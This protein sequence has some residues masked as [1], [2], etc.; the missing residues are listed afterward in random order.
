[1]CGSYGD[2]KVGGQFKACVAILV[3]LVASGRCLRLGG[4]LMLEPC[5]NSGCFFNVNLV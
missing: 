5:V 3:V 2:A 1:M 4:A